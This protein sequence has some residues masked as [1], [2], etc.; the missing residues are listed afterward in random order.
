M[1]ANLIKCECDGHQ[2]G[3]YALMAVKLPWKGLVAACYRCANREV[4]EGKARGQLVAIE[5]LETLYPS[6]FC[7]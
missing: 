5:S 2:G 6:V 4:R 1:G 7:A 3:G